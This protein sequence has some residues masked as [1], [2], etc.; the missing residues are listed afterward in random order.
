MGA[1]AEHDERSHRAGRKREPPAALGTLACERAR[2]SKVLATGS[3]WSKLRRGD[4]HSTPRQ[5]AWARS[6]VHARGDGGGEGSHLRARKRGHETHHGRGQAVRR[7]SRVVQRVRYRCSRCHHTAV[8]PVGRVSDAVQRRAS[9]AVV[10]EAWLCGWPRQGMSFAGRVGHASHHG[11]GHSHC[12]R[13]YVTSLSYSCEV[14]ECARLPVAQ[15]VYGHSS[16]YVIVCACSVYV[17]SELKR[18]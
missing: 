5:S 18:L 14:G 3:G 15:I 7:C 9:S 4:Y 8:W 11:H 6:H 17:R 10:W 2:E 12:S 1:Q 13:C 16:T